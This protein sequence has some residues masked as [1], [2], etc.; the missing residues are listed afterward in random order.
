MAMAWTVAAAADPAAPEL[1]VHNRGIGGQNSRQ[2]RARFEQDVVALKPDYVLIYFGLNDTLNEPA[3]VSIEEFVENL[4]WMVARSRQAGIVPVLCTIHAVEETALLKR[5]KRES[6][7]QEG[8]NGRIGR[9]NDAIRKLAADQHVLL[10]DFAARVAQAQKDN[11][12][13][14]AGPNDL[15]RPD[16]V[17]LTVA[18]NRALAQSFLDALAGKL[19]A[20]DVIVCLGDSVTYGVH[21]Q[22]AGTAEGDTY[23]AML[24]RL[25]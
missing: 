15:V 13:G 2:A 9:Y 4:T 6:Y 23:P 3:F 24:R 1:T 22:G 18:G 21:H 19:Q 11:T 10:A 17:H 12:D 16:G 20:G 25:K 8:P 5:H 7:G 14:K